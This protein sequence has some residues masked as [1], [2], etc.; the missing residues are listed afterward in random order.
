[1]GR[2]PSEPVRVIAEVANHEVHVSVLAA[3]YDRKGMWLPQALFLQGNETELAE[4]ERKRSLHR[5]QFQMQRR[6][7]GGRFPHTILGMPRDEAIKQQFVSGGACAGRGTSREPNAGGTCELD[8]MLEA[9]PVQDD[10][11]KERAG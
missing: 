5:F 7:A 3:A 2:L 1:D 4:L 10:D 11:E 9:Q 6:S 8:G